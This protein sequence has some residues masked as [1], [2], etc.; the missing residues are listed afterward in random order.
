MASP[1]AAWATLVRHLRP[2][3]PER[4]PPPSLMRKLMNTKAF[5]RRDH[6]PTRAWGTALRKSCSQERGAQRQGPQGLLWAG[7]LS[8]VAREEEQCALESVW[9]R[10]S[11][12]PQ[13]RCGL[14]S[15]WGGPPSR[16]KAPAQWCLFSFFFFFGGARLWSKETRSDGET[17]LNL[18][19]A[20]FRPQVW[21]SSPSKTS[22][23]NP[24][25]LAG[26]GLLLLCCPSCPRQRPAPEPPLRR[27][28]VLALHCATCPSLSFQMVQGDRAAC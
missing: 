8:T 12:V 26:A 18:K 25:A 13:A 1:R 20:L 11:L 5:T 28:P 23:W 16:Q 15:G 19:Q 3:S 24:G 10:N 21:G 9:Q 17:Q 2:S 6:A 14:V 7:E 22:P 4:L 27:Q